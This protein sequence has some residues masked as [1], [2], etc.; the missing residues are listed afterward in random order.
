MAFS[1][2]VG[3][4]VAAGQKVLD[5]LDHAGIHVVVA[6]WAKTSDYDEPRFFIASPDFESDSK[7]KAHARVSNAVQPKFDWPAP[8]IVIL[9]MADPLVQSLRQMFRS[10]SSVDGMRLGGQ[11]IGNRYVED[12][13]VYLVR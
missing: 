11:S 9:R 13:Y 1:T 3:F 12:A 2:L 6:L 7:L 4:D 8:N 5:A 10:A